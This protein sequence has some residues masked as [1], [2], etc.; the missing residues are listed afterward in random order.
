MSQHHPLLFGG[1]LSAITGGMLLL[2]ALL[3]L[4][5]GT[6]LHDQAAIVLAVVGCITLPGGTEVLLHQQY[7]AQETKGQRK[8]NVHG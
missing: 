8:G 3:L 2:L 5:A 1:W 6:T 7:E 4:T